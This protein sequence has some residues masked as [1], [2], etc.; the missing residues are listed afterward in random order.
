MK[1]FLGMGS[2]ELCSRI[3][4]LE[5]ELDLVRTNYH[6]DLLKWEARD[7]EEVSE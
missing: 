2:N 5:A 3:L 7:Q 1:R 6:Y 4:E